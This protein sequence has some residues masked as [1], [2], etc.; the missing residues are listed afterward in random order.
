MK[1]EFFRKTIH[2]T[3]GLIFLLLHWKGYLTIWI[4]SGAFL[5]ALIVTVV[6]S[7]NISKHFT[8][9]ITRIE[10]PGRIKGISGVT[11]MVGVM[12][13]FI[14]FS[15]E[16]VFAAAIIVLTLGDGFSGLV[17]HYY[18]KKKLFYN[19]KK[20]V[21]GLLTGV[22]ASTAGVMLL[23]P[24]YIAL[25]GSVITLLIETLPLKILGWEVDDNLL[26]PLISGAFF[27]A[28]LGCV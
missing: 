1:G 20:S 10:R 27:Y 3:A 5:I 15:Q 22:L 28:C 26:V 24:W 18:G 25:A 9:L 11:Y 23:F 14:L 16:Q 21:E 17:D 6:A 2:I 13:A 19:K 7:S 12:L 8:S 4:L